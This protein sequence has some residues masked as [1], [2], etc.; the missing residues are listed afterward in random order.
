MSEDE[1]DGTDYDEE[2]IDIEFDNGDELY[3]QMVDD[4][5][6]ELSAWLKDI[7]MSARSEQEVKNGL[8]EAY[9]SMVNTKRKI[10]YYKE[11]P[12]RFWD[13]V[14]SEAH[15]MLSEKNVEQI[16]W[17]AIAEEAN[18]HERTNKEE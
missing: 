3:D 15:T 10:S 12:M 14:Y 16:V 17:A 11:Q 9:E 1:I 7:V 6:A 13:H 5:I 8:Q 4:E 18:K 2:P